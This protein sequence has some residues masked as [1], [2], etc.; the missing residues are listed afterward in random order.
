LI[1]PFFKT[2]S[3]LFRCLKAAI[4][5]SD[6]GFEPFLFVFFLSYII[7]HFM[8]RNKQLVICIGNFGVFSVDLSKDL[9]MSR[10]NALHSL[11]C[12]VVDGW[13]PRHLWMMVDCW[14]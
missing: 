14:G 6:M 8:I 7:P 12:W 10:I 3:S 13:L 5:V 9:L 4:L 1:D 2:P 11:I